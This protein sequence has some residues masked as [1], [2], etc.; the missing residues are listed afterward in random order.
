M[1]YLFIDT[2]VWTLRINPHVQ[3][4]RQ[5]SDQMNMN[6]QQVYRLTSSFSPAACFKLFTS[7]ML[8]AFHQ[9]ATHVPH[10]AISRIH[11][12]NHGSI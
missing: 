12:I 5:P 3:L 11:D 2:I 9:L 8:Q 7:G 1:P 10:G 4:N 6:I